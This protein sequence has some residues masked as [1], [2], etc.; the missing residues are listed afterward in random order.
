MVLI[1][2]KANLIR[3]SNIRKYDINHAN[4]HPV[5]GWMSCILNNRNHI[6]TLLS[7]VHQ[8]STTSVRKLN[9]IHNSSLLIKQK[10][11]NNT[12]MVTVNIWNDSKWIENYLQV[13][14]DQRHERRWFLMQLPSIAPLIQVSKPDK[15][16]KCQH[17]NS[18]IDL[19]EIDYEVNLP[20]RCCQL[21]QE[22]QQPTLI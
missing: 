13:Q 15:K 22:Q 4:K 12:I 7:H 2:V 17:K 18:I 1:G 9:S 8:I 5:L 10:Q 20:S 16:E 19:W 11:V 21:H 6:R 14:Q 3:L